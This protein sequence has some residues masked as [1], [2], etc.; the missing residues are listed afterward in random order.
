[1]DVKF[2]IKSD[3]ICLINELE[4]CKKEKEEEDEKKNTKKI[5][6]KSSRKQILWYNRI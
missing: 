2:F 6:I 1:M 4:I 3:K 5:L